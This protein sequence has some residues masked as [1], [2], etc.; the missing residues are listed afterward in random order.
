MWYI[1]IASL[2]IN[3]LWPWLRDL[4]GTYLGPCTIL[5]VHAW[6]RGTFSQYIPG[7][8]LDFF[9]VENGLGFFE[10]VRCRVWDLGLGFF[11]FTVNF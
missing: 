2:D 4:T 3:A 7:P 10:C 11:W 1:E 6:A 9:L 5:P 8:M